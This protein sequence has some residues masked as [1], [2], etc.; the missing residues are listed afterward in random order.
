MMKLSSNNT[1]IPALKKSIL[2]DHQALIGHFEQEFRNAP[3]QVIRDEFFLN[4][5]QDDIT[6]IRRQLERLI[7]Y[8]ST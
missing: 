3:Q 8:D 1:V 2:L 6:K 5:D 7:N 4:I